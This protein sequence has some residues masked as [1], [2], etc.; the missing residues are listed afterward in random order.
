MTNLFAPRP[1]LAAAIAIGA[2]AGQGHTSPSVDALTALETRLEGIRRD[3][4]VAAFGFAITDRRQTLVARNRGWADLETRRPV[5]ASTRFRVG[6]I[7]KTFTGVGLLTLVESGKVDLDARVTNYLEPP[8]FENP[9]RDQ[10]P[11]RVAH[12]MEHTAGFSDISREEFAFNEP[13][14]PLAEVLAR[15]RA[16]HR[17]RWKP[18]LHSS[19]TNL[20]PGIAG[21]VMEVAAGES[22]ESYMTAQVLEPLGMASSTW[23][24]DAETAAAL[25]T[26]YNTDGTTRIP[27]WHMAYRPFGALN[28][29][30][31]DMARFIRMLLNGGRS[32]NTRLL[33]AASIQRLQ[34]PGTTL[35][36][37][38]G[39]RYGYGLGSY[40][41]FRSGIKFHGH[42]GDGDGYLAHYGYAPQAGLGYFVV[43]TAFK[44]KS[45]RRMR[46]ALEQFV[47][48]QAPAQKT[49]PAATRAG[50]LSRWMGSYTAVTARFGEP[51]RTLEIRLSGDGDRLETRRG[52]AGWKPLI[53]AGHGRFRRP[54]QPEATV[55][56]VASSE[57]DIIY[58]GDEGN[59]AKRSND[60]A[61]KSKVGLSADDY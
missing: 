1:L 29:T 31:A 14:T 15:F 42:G 3:E 55:A 57:G 45:L 56:I 13:L 61:A 59:F 46:R 52:A 47:V 53:P 19:Y 36:A 54:D 5:T 35:A 17:T 28:T 49:P 58:Q 60:P 40:Q 9:Y 2:F 4:G 44:G 6:S 50:D 34:T 43:I 10:T 32:G 24:L 37:R 8:P 11:V 30:P 48:D 33:E 51:K 26:G 20:G 38:A 41:W 22:F 23:H 18:G 7:T 12:L 39:V 25:A 27:Y 16:N 21:R